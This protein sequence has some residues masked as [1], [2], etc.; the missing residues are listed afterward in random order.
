MR[1]LLRLIA[2]QLLH[3][4]ELA[5]ADGRIYLECRECQRETAGWEWTVRA[6]LSERMRRFR[7]R[8]RLASS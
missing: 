6:D 7:K 3:D 1:R 5:L 2:C 4:P 8:L